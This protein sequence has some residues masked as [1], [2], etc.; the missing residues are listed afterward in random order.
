M[1]H[2]NSF[3]RNCFGLVNTPGINNLHNK[4]ECPNCHANFVTGFDE[5]NIRQCPSCKHKFIL[6]TKIDHGTGCSIC[7][8]KKKSVSSNTDY[9]NE[10]PALMSDG[11]FI[12]YYNSTN[13]LTE[14]I[15]KSNGIRSP[16]EFRNFMQKNG[17]QFMDAERKHIE[18]EN[19]CSPNIACS[20]GW[21]DLWTKNRG[22][23]SVY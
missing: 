12:T 3:S 18:K 2:C 17:D 11:R 5:N 16:N 7:M 6:G 10:C 9:R 23:W 13:E 14:A 8:A 15:R 20:Q 1:T 21:Y 19:T 22:N 4:L